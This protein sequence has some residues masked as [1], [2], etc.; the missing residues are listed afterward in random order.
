MPIKHIHVDQIGYRP[1]DTKVAVIQNPQS[2]YGSDEPYIVGTTLQVRRRGTGEVVFSGTPVAWNAGATHT[3][4]GDKVHHFDFSAVT[5]PGVYEIVDTKPGGET[6]Y[7]FR[8]H[9]QVYREALIAA[10]RTYY[11]QR[12]SHTVLR[13]YAGHWP[14]AAA[15]NQDQVARLITNNTPATERDLR[16]GH[17]DAGDTNRYCTFAANYH[18]LIA[19][20]ECH[21]SLY[22]RLSLGIPES[23]ASLPDVLAEIKWEI[24]SWVKAQFP[25]GSVALKV[26]VST[27]GIEAW[28]V[29]SDTRPRFYAAP[30]TSSTIAAAGLFAHF[31]LV[32]RDRLGYGGYAADLQAR[33]I[34]AWSWYKARSTKDTAADDPDTVSPRVQ[35]GR[36]DQT[37]DWQLA[38][39]FVAAVYLLHLTGNSQYQTAIA[40]TYTKIHPI[41]VDYNWGTE[42]AYEAHAATHYCT[43]LPAS[44]RSPAIVDAIQERYNSI[45]ANS[46]GFGMQTDDPYRTSLKE[47][48]YHW[49][50]NFKVAAYGSQ[51]LRAIADGKVP[52]NRQA[53]VRARG[54]ACLNY[55]H[56][57]NPFGKVY[58]SGARSLGC[59]N[60]VE[61]FYHY[62]WGRGAAATQDPPPGF[63]VG[64][65]SQYY[66]GDQTAILD[67]PIQKRYAEIPYLNWQAKPWEFTEPSSTGY[68]PFYLELLT[69]AQ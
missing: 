20:Y 23:R 59:S 43:R 67:Q 14:R 47:W 53:S 4:S 12:S 33:A 17:F 32:M 42:R 5:R 30:T 40:A 10:W 69:L 54:I 6:S 27:P 46:D 44:L 25:D 64:G 45:V 3:L 7:S 56:G 29:S 41:S 48:D 51:N 28:P 26:G 61:I 11:H 39:E 37:E 60:A 15:Y 19:L 13:R 38:A 50:S 21:S 9:P 58:L 55:L 52:A 36:A 35:A 62:Q 57:V 16:G 31:A 22:D 1:D 2:G 24:D 49:G 34:S 68:Q 8:I 66:S 63:L 65:V 18:T